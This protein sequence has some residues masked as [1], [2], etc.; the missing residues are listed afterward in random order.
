MTQFLEPQ[1]E[2]LRA[3]VEY[4]VAC[5]VSGD[6]AEFG[7]YLGRTAS[8]LAEFMWEIEKRYS[9]SD[10]AHNINQRRLWAFDSFEGFPE[11]SHPID[12]DAPHVKAGLWYAGQPAG[13][14]PEY[15]HADCARFIDADRISVVKGWYKDVLPKLPARVR[16]AVVHIDCDFYESTKEVLDRLLGGGLLSDGCTILFDDWYCNRGSPEFGEQ[17]AWRGAWEQV[18]YV[19]SYRY[20]DWG[21]Y[22]VTGRRFIVHGGKT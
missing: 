6:V 15:V 8:A 3:A 21:P 10:R 4:A 12:S 11:P 18:S 2:A 17:R 16:F 7:C 13:G 5:G 14:T 1:R 9:G 22:G 19:Q 20:S